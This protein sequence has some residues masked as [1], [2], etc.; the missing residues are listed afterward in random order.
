MVPALQS[1]QPVKLTRHWTCLLD[2]LLWLETSTGLWENRGT[3]GVLEG[4]LEKQPLFETNRVN[5]N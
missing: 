4:F 5:K 1:S 3:I 2:G